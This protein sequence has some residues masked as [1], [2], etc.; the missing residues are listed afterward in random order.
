[1]EQAVERAVTGQADDPDYGTAWPAG[2]TLQ[3]AQLADGVLSVDLSGVPADRPAGMSPPRRSSRS[4]RRSA[5][6][7]ARSA[8]SCP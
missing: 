6:R 4:T 2:T 1:M 5:R 7:R 3:K 8:R